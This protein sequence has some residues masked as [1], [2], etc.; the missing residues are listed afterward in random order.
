MSLIVVKSFIIFSSKTIS[1]VSSIWSY[2]PWSLVSNSS[3]S[4]TFLL[5]TTFP[6]NV[7]NNSEIGLTIVAYKSNLTIAL[8]FKSVIKES[9]SLSSE[10]NLELFC[11]SILSFIALFLRLSKSFTAFS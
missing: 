6:A 5:S 4:T 11:C 9:N 2:S 8:L 7:L 3:K 10:A 1:W